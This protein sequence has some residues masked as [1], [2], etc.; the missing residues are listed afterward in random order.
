[1][2]SGIGITSIVAG[3]G[4][5]LYGLFQICSEKKDANKKT[6]Q[7][8]LGIQC[9]VGGIAIAFFGTLLLLNQKTSQESLEGRA[10]HLNHESLL[11]TQS[12]PDCF[13]RVSD[14]CGSQ[15]LK[16]FNFLRETGE[17]ACENFTSLVYQKWTLIRASEMSEPIN[18]RLDKNQCPFISTRYSCEYIVDPTEP[19]RGVFTLFQN[20]TN[21]IEVQASDRQA[22][23]IEAF[24]REEFP[25]KLLTELFTKKILSIKEAV[26]YLA[27]S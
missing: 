24:N 11:E 6:E 4:T 14:T 26:I 10:T 8:A 15:I 16:I 7:Q 3:I 12:V 9:L 13:S 17:L 23:C 19:V 22:F 25:L 1:M 20:K 5:S 18:W 27:A 2:N 21:Q